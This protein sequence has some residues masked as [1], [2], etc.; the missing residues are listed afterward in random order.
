MD[1]PGQVGEQRSQA[2]GVPSS[3]RVTGATQLNSTHSRVSRGESGRSSAAYLRSIGVTSCGSFQKCWVAEQ[4]D[5]GRVSPYS[6]CASWA[7][8]LALHWGMSGRGVA[9]SL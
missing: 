3:R 8:S 5:E 2:E 4:I 1:A 6:D 7:S 9:A